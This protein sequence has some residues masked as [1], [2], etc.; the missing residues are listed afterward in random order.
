M[1]YLFFFL[2]CFSSITF[3][4]AQ[5]NS[6][7]KVDS[8]YKEDQFYA[9]ITYNLLG[10]KPKKLN[11]S[12]F[13]LGFHL[14][15]IKD[16]PINKERNIA[17]GLGLGYSA[18]SFNQD[19]LINKNSTDSFTYSIIENSQS[20]S[21]NKFSIHLIEVP[22]EFRWRTSTPSE[23]NFWRIYAGFKFGYVLANTSKYE[24]DLGRIKHTNNNDFNAFQYGLTLS[25]GYNTW[26]FHIY[27]PLNSIF[28]NDAQLNG[29]N[30]DVN[31]VKIGLM[32]YI[33]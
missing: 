28:S 22:F 11:Q 1:R 15:F 2:F 33:L 23:Y 30:L 19:L 9:G 10:N 21:K 3:C 18:N 29:E 5:E 8:L 17:F 27:Y 26:N 20:Y 6:I 25:A 4:Y 7:K 24:G 16:M 32:F 13:S 14:G 31:A 12:G